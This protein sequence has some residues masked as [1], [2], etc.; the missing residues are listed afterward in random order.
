MRPGRPGAEWSWRSGGA[1]S[2]SST[3]D[4]KVAS[5]WSAGASSSGLSRGGTEVTQT[6]EVL[7][8][9]AD[10]L[11]V[12]EAGAVAVLDMMKDAALQGMPETLDALKADAESALR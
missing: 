9:Y 8:A 7:P 1:S 5:R 11:G 4:S 12:D 10:G 2:R 3:T 6:W